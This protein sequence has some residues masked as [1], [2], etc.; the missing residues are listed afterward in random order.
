MGP[1]YN[2]VGDDDD[3]I[4]LSM[5]DCRSYIQWK[6]L[7]SLDSLYELMD[8]TEEKQSREYE[9]LGLCPLDD[10]LA[11]CRSGPRRAGLTMQ[12]GERQNGTKTGMF[13]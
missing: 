1:S 2:D 7:S 8:R 9:P 11:T 12:Q 6:P 10:C 3:A 5:F 4:D 13:L